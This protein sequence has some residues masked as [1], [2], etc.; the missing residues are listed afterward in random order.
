VDRKCELSRGGGLYRISNLKRWEC[1]ELGTISSEDETVDR[2][3][4]NF[5]FGLRVICGA[6]AMDGHHVSW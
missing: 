5:G 3:K 2:I 1:W 4:S 6:R